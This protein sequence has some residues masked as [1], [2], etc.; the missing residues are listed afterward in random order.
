MVPDARADTTRFGSDVL[1]ELGEIEIEHPPGTFAITPAS[2]IAIDAIVRHQD[3]LAG[4]GVDWGSGT[5]CMAIVAARIPDVRFIIG[6]EIVAANCAVARRNA[7]RNVVDHKVRFLSSDAWQ[8]LDTADR[9]WFD[10][11]AGRIDFVLANPPSS[12][13]VGDGFD[14][15]RVV[16]RGARRFLRPGGVIFLNI[17]EQYGQERLLGLLRDVPGF[18]HDGLLVT[19]D[20]VPFD[21]RRTD[22][23]LDV[24]TYA[25]EEERG[26][27]LYTFR[28]AADSGRIIDARSALDRYRSTGESPLSRWQVHAFV[29]A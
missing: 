2:R 10:E 6:L 1:G 23:M 14:F 16:L 15:R 13:P 25:A 3:R 22:L 20:F 11:H 5:G 29:R 21:M 12:S 28:D 8:P 17:S 7:Q 27:P 18:H 4:T 26:G 19:T 9:A 24:E